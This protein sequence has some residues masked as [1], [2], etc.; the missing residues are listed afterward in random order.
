[1]SLMLEKVTNAYSNRLIK[2]VAVVFA[3]LWVLVAVPEAVIWI[4]HATN[5]TSD[6]RSQ[7]WQI[8]FIAIFLLN[9]LGCFFRF[10]G[11]RWMVLGPCLLLLFRDYSF[12]AIPREL[13]WNFEEILAAIRLALTFGTIAMVLLWG[14][15]VRS[16]EVAHP[17]LFS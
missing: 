4:G 17:A 5:A 13:D 3:L 1:M 12:L 15:L 7:F 2:I 6:S 16:D 14:R 10:P 9:A 8:L 11:W